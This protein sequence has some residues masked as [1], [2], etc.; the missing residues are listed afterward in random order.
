MAN[1]KKKAP[2]SWVLPTVV[3]SFIAIIASTNSAS[4]ANGVRD[5]VTKRNTQD[6]IEVKSLFKDFIND[7]GK[8]HREDMK[9]QNKATQEF[10]EKVLTK[11]EDKLSPIDTMKTDIAIIKY[12]MTKSK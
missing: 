5:Q 11:I 2:W 12:K 6:I 1:T 9:A 4:H 8:I 3:S 7:H 10:Y